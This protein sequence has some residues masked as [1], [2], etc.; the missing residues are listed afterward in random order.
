MLAV[1]V[2]VVSLLAIVMFALQNDYASGGLD[3]A[4]S[5]GQGAFAAS[6]G[7][8]AGYPPNLGAAGQDAYTA[9][10]LYSQGF[11]TGSQ[12]SISARA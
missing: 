2:D 11:A 10:A 4:Y 8:Q 7:G 9:N 6:Y 5:G 3:T 1:C 12:V